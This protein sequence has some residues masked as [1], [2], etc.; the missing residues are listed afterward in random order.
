MIRTNK[1]RNGFTLVELLVVIAIIA[2]LM[3]LL[4][5]AV[6]KVREAAARTR[7]QNNLKNLGTALH[8][9][10][11]SAGNYLPPS[12]GTASGPVGDASLFFCILPQIEQENLYRE[13]LTTPTTQSLAI[14]SLPILMADL[15]ATQDRTKAL[16]SYATNQMVFPGG[17]VGGTSTQ[18][19]AKSGKRLTELRSGT[20]NI[21]FLMERSAQA[22][23]MSVEH[24]WYW[25]NITLLPNP[26]AV[27]PFQVA[28]AKDQIDDSF[29]QAFSASG[30][31]ILMGD[32]SV[33]SVAPSVKPDIWFTA[34]NPDTNQSLG[35]WWN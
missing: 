32:S 34:N 12:F 33:R 16:T 6:Q 28:P 31:Q 11:S 26:Q 3:S 15:D 17:Q 18:F 20:S 21:V 29:A 27:P 35:E 7:S 8:N 23:N 4:L 25:Q 22:N 30:L 10:A 24:Y 5:P 19:S 14:K 9:Y 13:F 2:V 1:Q